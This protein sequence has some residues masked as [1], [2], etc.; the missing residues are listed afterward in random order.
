MPDDSRHGNPSNASD[1]KNGSVAGM[2][3][4]TERQQQTAASYDDAVQRTVAHTADFSRHADTVGSGYSA[5]TD[6]F[7]ASNPIAGSAQDTERAAIPSNGQNFSALNAR[8]TYG[9]SF[10]DSQSEQ[11]A[12]KTGMDTGIDQLGQA[13]VARSADFGSDLTAVVQAD[14]RDAFSGA[15]DAGRTG[16]TSRQAVRAGFQSTS[17][18]AGHPRRRG[19][20]N[21]AS[22]RRLQL[23]YGAAG[24]QLPVFGRR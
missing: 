12:F 6:G 16:S 7:G 1:S 18:P 10:G 8:E 3:S 19:P 13:G 15:Y 23:P 5:R 11:N 2:S 9:S 21:T 14:A 24:F 17:G 20:A 22:S 4:E